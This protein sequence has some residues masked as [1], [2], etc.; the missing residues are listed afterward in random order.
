MSL[1]WESIDIDS[2]RK[3]LNVLKQAKI[4]GSNNIPAPGI[5]SYSETE[6]RIK[7]EIKSHYLKEVSN[8]VKASEIF[9]NRIRICKELTKEDGHKQLLEETKSKWALKFGS[10]QN[11]YQAAKS[12][13][14]DIRQKIDTFRVQNNIFAGREPMERTQFKFLLA[15]MVPLFL[16]SI[17]IFLNVSILSPVLGGATAISIS[18]MVSII[19][20]GLSFLVGRLC[21]TNLFHP[22][23]TS[24][25]K[26]LYYTIFALFLLI[27][28]YVNFMMGVFRGSMDIAQ[29]AALEFMDKQEIYA[30]KSREALFASVFPFND[31]DKITFDSVWLILVGF[32]FGL[33]SV[34][35][36]YYFD[37]PIN[38]YG[39]LGRKKQRAE[40]EFDKLRSE[41]PKILDD[42]TQT[43]F[44]ELK[45]KR[46]ERRGASSEW[47]KIIDEL[48]AD[49]QNY[50]LFCSN[51]ETALKALLT[52]YKTENEKFRTEAAPDHFENEIDTSYIQDF[53]T[54][55]LN[56]RT[57]L[58]D[59]SEKERQ[60]EIDEEIIDKEYKETFEE[61]TTFFNSQRDE[62]FKVVAV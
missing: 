61:Y 9:E 32:F 30:E 6:N 29:Q 44:G 62:M 16:A 7:E 50:Y 48:Q 19:N 57:E 47:G 33:F 54:A 37:D 4:D 11:D 22:V 45:Q 12:K 38:G 20:V 35:D 24:A 25:A 26:S 41:G 43:V 31:L 15:L 56:I 40:T 60:I 59:D 49:S 55:H 17:E 53:P 46:E 8:S 18:F 27:L 2:F 36:G 58:R 14:S 3:K 51:I 52:S 21:L 42:Y 28:V 34:L 39:S 13:L 10:F 5:S 23:S 1:V